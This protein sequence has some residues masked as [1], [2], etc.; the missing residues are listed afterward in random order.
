VWGDNLALLILQVRSPVCCAKANV[1]N[2][3]IAKDGFADFVFFRDLL[4][5]YM[6]EVL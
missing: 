1:L 5:V 4:A 3:G 6:I 2:I